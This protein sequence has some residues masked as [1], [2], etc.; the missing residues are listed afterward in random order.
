MDV[1]PQA[2]DIIRTWLFSTI[3][4]SQ[5][6]HDELPW[7]NAAISGW[8]L[9]P[10]RKKMSKSKGNVVTPM[11]L[12]EEYGADAV[13]YWAANGRPGTDTAFDAQQMKVGRRLAV[14]LLNAS[15]FALADLPPEG[16][17]LTSPLDR[18]MIARLGNVVAEATESFEQYDYAR[19][20]ERVES[21]FWWY[22]DYY[23]EL[24][25]GRRYD[26]RDGEPPT[27]R[28]ARG[29]ASVSRALRR[30]LSVF[31]RLLAPFL[32]FVCEE[33]WSWWQ[34]G[35]VHRASWPDA[36]ELVAALGDAQATDAA[37]E[38]V[39]LA[40]AAD[41]LKE[42]RKAKSQAQRP[43][44]APVARVVVHDGAERLGGDAAG[45]RRPAPGGLDCCDRERRGRRVRRGGRARGRAGRGHVARH[46]GSRLR[47]R[48]IGE[49]LR[50]I[51]AHDNSKEAAPP[52][53]ERTARR[54]D[55]DRSLCDVRLRG[56]ALEDHQ[57]QQCGKQP[58]TADADVRRRQQ[59]L[60]GMTWSNFGAP[61]A[62]GQGHVRDEHVRTELRARQGRQLPGERQ[63][64][65]QK[66]CK[67]ATVYAKLS[68]SYP[69]ARKPPPSEP[70]K[71]FSAARPESPVADR[72]HGAE[73]RRRGP[74]A[75]AWIG[76]AA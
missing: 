47:P 17:A 34:E 64:R 76:S 13:R 56:L 44:R 26:S 5:L 21:F 45:R 62:A 9:D 10:D 67:G 1:R 51:P 24:V 60:K 39:A 22:C 68:L 72:G 4:R 49:W 43:M 12:L 55:R 69:G 18:A 52:T 65:R 28:S 30:S 38:D 27:R 54:C 42:V 63:G 6:E 23:L 14:K 41:V 46:A 8:V 61:T 75:L 35:S 37:A 74:P 25:K 58:E 32:P 73:Q 31:Q 3:L 2:H 50:G 66:K 11:H 40:V 29:Q 33:V 20:L 36:E 70:R 48:R 57:L 53:R 71:W 7:R 16:D 15:K 59:V 19:A